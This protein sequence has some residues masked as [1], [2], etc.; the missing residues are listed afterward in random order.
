[1]QTKKHYS[2]PEISGDKR[3]CF[4]SFLLFAH[5]NVSLIIL[6]KTKKHP[7]YFSCIHKEIKVIMT[8]WICNRHV[9]HNSVGRHK[10]KPRAC[11]MPP[12]EVLRWGRPTTCWWDF[13]S[14]LGISICHRFTAEVSRAKRPIIPVTVTLVHLLWVSALFICLWLSFYTY[15]YFLGYQAKCITNDFS[16]FWWLL[17]C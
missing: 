17:H 6:W 12:C 7:V 13:S 8:K 11:R 1:M 4:W 5:C 9:T 16:K 10:L 14:D 3:C 2:W 15:L